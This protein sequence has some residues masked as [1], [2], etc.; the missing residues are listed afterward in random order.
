MQTFFLCLLFLYLAYGS[1]VAQNETD[2][3]ACENATTCATCTSGPKS[4]WDCI[5]CESS[6]SCLAGMF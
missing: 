5:W 2:I 3:V 4:G 6:H 1:L